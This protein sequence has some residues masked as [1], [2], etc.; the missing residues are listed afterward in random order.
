MTCGGLWSKVG[1]VCDIEKLKVFQQNENEQVRVDEAESRLIEKEIRM[2]DLAKILISYPIM[3]SKKLNQNDINL[4]NA[5]ASVDN[6]NSFE[7]N[8]KQ[9]WAYMKEMR[10]AGLC[11][12]CAGD[13]YNYFYGDKAIITDSECQKMSQSCKGHFNHVL[14]LIRSN[15][16]ILKANYIRNFNITQK[17][18]KYQKIEKKALMKKLS[19]IISQH[20]NNTLNALE[21]LS[22][23]QDLL[24]DS[25]N[26]DKLCARIFRVTA[27]PSIFMLMRIMKECLQKIE[28]INIQIPEIS[29]WV[30]TAGDRALGSESNSNLALTEDE[31][32][33]AFTGDTV[34]MKKSDNMFSAFDGAKGTTL[35]LL[36]PDVKP[37]SFDRSFP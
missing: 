28:E 32:K 17:D 4:I 30:N 18:L 31:I 25:Q 26:Q 34:F 22:L 16:S 24:V 11:S 33:D 36:N 1:T 7:R 13:N 19:E 14:K 20:E 12:V 6:H 8:M 15:Y 10:A 23:A 3:N 35:G 9:C 27:T 37:M 5:R 21:V 2:H 29:N